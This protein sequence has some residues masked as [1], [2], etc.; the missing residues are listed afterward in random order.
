MHKAMVWTE[1]NKV[2]TEDQYPYKG[3]DEACNESAVTG[4]VGCTDAVDV[5]PKS[6]AALMASIEIAPTS[7]AIVANCI[8]FQVY[9]GGVFDNSDVMYPCGNEYS[10]LDHGVLAVG[11]GTEDGKD[12]YLVKNSWGSSWG[13]S[14][15]IKIANNDQDGN[16][17]CGIQLDAT[18]AVTN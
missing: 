10:G 13:E 18:R 16:G 12:Y 17:Q 2:T 1:A 5:T 3:K 11:Y 6:S 9:S 8:A 15:Y 4:V 7:V 14:G